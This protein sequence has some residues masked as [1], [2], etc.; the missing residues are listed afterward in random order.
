MCCHVARRRRG[1]QWLALIAAG[2]ILGGCERAPVDHRPPHQ[3]KAL[4]PPIP[5][6]QIVTPSRSFQVRGLVRGIS[7]D[8]QTITVRHEPIPDFMPSMTMEL[9]VRDVAGLRGIKIGDTIEFR[10]RVDDVE[11]WVEELKPV[12]AGGTNRPAHS[13]VISSILPEEGPLKVGDPLPEVELMSET[14]E[15]VRLSDFAGEAVALTFIFSRC[16]LPDFCPRMNHN[17]SRAREILSRTG[18]SPQKWRFLS[19]SFDSEFDQPSVLHS[20]ASVYRGPDSRRW[21]FAVAP[22]KALATLSACLD[23]HFQSEAGSFAHNLRTVVLS[24][25]GRI[26][27]YFNGN[28]WTA[29]ELAEALLNASRIND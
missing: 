27:R 14:G 2:L 8:S 10:L 29:E 23:F 13:G 20:H 15:T 16:R 28:K 7:L 9:P 18:S 25:Q 17:F 26:T 3:T 19:I 1:S 11:S 4:P 12:G 21:L 24:P 5:P 22:P 6:A